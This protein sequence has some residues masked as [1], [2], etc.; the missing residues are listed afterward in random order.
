MMKK[1]TYLLTILISTFFLFSCEKQSTD[2]DY[3]ISIDETLDINLESNR[4]TGYSWYWENKNEV[5]I[6]DTLKIKYIDDSD[7]KGAPGR[8]IW[9]FIGKHKGHCTIILSYKQ[10]I[11]STEYEKKQTFLVTVE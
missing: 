8:E 1:Y 2:D 5:S 3:N 9:S 11:N 10:S 4:S 6:L 7:K